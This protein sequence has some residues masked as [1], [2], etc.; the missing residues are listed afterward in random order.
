MLLEQ[1][2]D[3]GG[4]AGWQ[5]SQGVSTQQ[6]GQGVSLGWRALAQ[7]QVQRLHAIFSTLVHVPPRPGVTPYCSIAMP[8]ETAEAAHLGLTTPA[9]FPGL[10]R[11]WGR[12]RRALMMPEPWM[13]GRGQWAGCKA[14]YGQWPPCPS[15][16]Q[17]HSTQVSA[18]QLLFPRG[19]PRGVAGA[20]VTAL[21]T[22]A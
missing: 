14:V 1:S 13:P 4:M 22:S 5:G 11:M 19:V 2:G 7:P 18:G 15:A 17:Q 8:Q 9:P 6:L 3:V 12:G 16:G 20:S 21:Q 10:G